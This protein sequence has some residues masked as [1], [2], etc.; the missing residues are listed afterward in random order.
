MYKTIKTYD[1]RLTRKMSS[2][3]IYVGVEDLYITILSECSK[4]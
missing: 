1:I 4:T 2:L 3:S